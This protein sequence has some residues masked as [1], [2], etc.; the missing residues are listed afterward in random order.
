MKLAG[1][2]A[3]LVFGSAVVVALLLLPV[4]GLLVGLRWLWRRGV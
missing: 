2:G 3:H 1:P 4:I